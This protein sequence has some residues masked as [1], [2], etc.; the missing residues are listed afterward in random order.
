MIRLYHSNF[1]ITRKVKHS[2]YIWEE[3]L[4]D[5]LRLDIDNWSIKNKNI[6]FLTDLDSNFTANLWQMG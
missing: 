1:Q 2:G 6:F 5:N 3:A 4:S